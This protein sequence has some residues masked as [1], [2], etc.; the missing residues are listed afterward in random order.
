MNEISHQHYKVFIYTDQQY[1]LESADN[2]RRY[3]L[4]KEVFET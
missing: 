3:K 4:I 1:T 2:L